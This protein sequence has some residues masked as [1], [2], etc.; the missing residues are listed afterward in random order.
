MAE[1]IILKD[2]AI[3]FRN[4]E[5]RPTPYD[6][7]GGKHT[8]AIFLSSEQ[9]L[10]LSS[11]GWNVKFPEDYPDTNKNPYLS[12]EVSIDMYP[13]K[14]VLVA[15]EEANILPI[16]QISML[17][18]ADIESADVIIRPYHWEAAGNTGVKAYCK[19]IYV[20]LAVDELSR[21]YGV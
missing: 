18:W 7:E 3:G 17:D 8:F 12:V 9:A 1:Q 19:A 13:T 2:V 21:R 4:F 5:G 16:D 10:K 6:R 15:G 20:R 14:V 11:E